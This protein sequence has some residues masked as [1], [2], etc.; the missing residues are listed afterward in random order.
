MLLDNYLADFYAEKVLKGRP[1]SVAAQPLKDA[2]VSDQ[3]LKDA[4]KQ[5]LSELNKL[6]ASTG[7]NLAKRC[8]VSS[9]QK[10]ALEEVLNG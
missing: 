3:S 4:A 6:D 10:T 5:K 8:Y 9:V 7:G 1:V 2:I